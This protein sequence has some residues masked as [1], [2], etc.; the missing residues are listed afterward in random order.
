MREEGQHEWRK[1]NV[2]GTKVNMA[3]ARTD[4]PP[5]RPSQQWL[6]ATLD[7]AYRHEIKCKPT[8]A[9]DGADHL[10]VLQL[11]QCREHA[12]SVQ[13]VLVTPVGG[14]ELVVLDTLL[15]EP[16]QSRWWRSRES[17]PDAIY[18]TQRT[19][20]EPASSRSAGQA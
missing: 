19:H 13:L 4:R 15:A 14:R 17:L 10:N 8:K 5:Q 11:R 16:D 2:S 18:E 3:A 9:H 7:Q 6:S 20:T 1:V 12:Q